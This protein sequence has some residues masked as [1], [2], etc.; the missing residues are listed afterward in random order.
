MHLLDDYWK[1]Y[2]G[3]CMSLEFFLKEHP[4]KEEIKYF[5]KKL[6]EIDPEI[7]HN[8]DDMIEIKRVI[9]EDD[10]DEEDEDYAYVHHEM[11]TPF[12]EALMSQIIKTN[13]D[14]ASDMLFYTGMH[15]SERLKHQV[16][17]PSKLKKLGLT[18]IY[19]S[20]K[21]IHDQPHVVKRRLPK[22]DF[23]IPELKISPK[24]RELI[25]KMLRKK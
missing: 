7:K 25:R 6:K 19:S 9:E 2:D 23:P 4:K 12:V 1:E 10:N 17:K 22:E 3:T 20:S 5:I 15:H 13:P 16:L 18:H 11:V 24:E 21:E 8:K 14:K